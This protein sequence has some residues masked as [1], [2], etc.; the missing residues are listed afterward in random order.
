MDAV[1]DCALR[2]SMYTIV[3]ER[4][5]ADAGG[6]YVIKMNPKYGTLVS[7]GI[8]HVVREWFIIMAVVW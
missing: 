2:R 1:F 4:G 5:R 8:S 3:M 7:R 6:K